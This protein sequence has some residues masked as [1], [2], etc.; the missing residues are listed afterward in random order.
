VGHSKSLPDSTT[1]KKKQQ[2][3]LHEA[4]SALSS[5]FVEKNLL[6]VNLKVLNQ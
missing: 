1:T 2:L 5:Y 4:Y 6:H 3:M